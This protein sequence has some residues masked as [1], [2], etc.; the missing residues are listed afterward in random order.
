MLLKLASPFLFLV[1]MQS[2][3]KTEDDIK[4]AERI[5][6]ACC[7][8]EAILALVNTFGNGILNGGRDVLWI[9]KHLLSPAYMGPANFSCL[10]GIGALISLVRYLESKKNMYLVM[11]IVF[12]GCI[13]WA[14]VRITMAGLVIATVIVIMLMARNYFVKYIIPLSIVMTFIICFF[15]VDAFRTRMFFGDKI[16]LSTLMHADIDKAASL[17]NTSGRSLLWGKVNKEFLHKE[18][19]LG[20]GVGAVD[21]WLDNHGGT[22]LHGEYLRILSD[23]GV[24]G[25]LL[26]IY[27]MLQFV[28]TLAGLYFN[29]C[30]GS[31]KISVVVAF[32]GLIFYL[33][34]LATDN[35]L[36][37]ISEFGLYVYSLLA[38]V[39]V[40]EQNVESSKKNIY[41]EKNII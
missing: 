17:V 22:R 1:I 18:P 20:S 38:F 26:Y 39:L 6:I 32:A 28:I 35:S 21:Y 11:Y 7:I 9:S 24:V 37:Y 4:K 31:I 13:F 33:T 10:I 34:T 19:L 14:F 16:E 40:K 12:A 29:K 2:Y 5:I 27:A 30:C 15:T 36:N 25:L 3:V 8:V 23:L 41:E